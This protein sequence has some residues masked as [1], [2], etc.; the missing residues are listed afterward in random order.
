MYGFGAEQLAGRDVPVNVVVPTGLCLKNPLA[1]TGES[2]SGKGVVTL[3]VHNGKVAPT[4]P[5]H[6]LQVP[7]VLAT[8]SPPSPPSVMVVPTAQAVD[9]PPPP[10][11][12]DDKE[13]TVLVTTPT[14][15]TKNFQPK[16]QR[17]KR[18]QGSL[19]T[20]QRR[21]RRARAEAR[22]EE[23]KRNSFREVGATWKPTGRSTGK[24]NVE[25]PMKKFAIAI[26]LAKD[27][28]NEATKGEQAAIAPKPEA[29]QESQAY[30]S[31]SEEKSSTDNRDRHEADEDLLVW[32]GE[33]DR[34]CETVN[35]Q[36]TSGGFDEE[37]DAPLPESLYL[38]PLVPVA[39][40]APVNPNDEI[41]LLEF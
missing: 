6:G 16:M 38:A 37:W 31:E 4:G 27:L 40:V 41:N 8:S 39:S 2:S 14:S 32:N 10:V 20:W 26:A 9:T 3:V 1:S 7:S 17:V 5:K 33:A 11:Q 25:E 15:Q 21:E 30:S 22:E 34:V 24:S 35:E 13:I 23:R 29:K 28:K 12:I 36:S 18:G 19:V